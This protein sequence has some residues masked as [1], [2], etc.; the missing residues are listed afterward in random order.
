MRILSVAHNHPS[1]HPGGTEIIADQLTLEYASRRDTSAMLLVGLD[2]YYRMPHSGTFLQAIPGRSDV[3]LF[4]SRGFDA[5]QQIQTRFDS[6]LF[7]LAWFLEEFRPEVVHIHHLNHFGIEFLALVRRIV[8]DAVVVY[9]LH[10]YYLICPNDGQMV[11]TKSDRLCRR[12]SPDACRACFPERPGVVFQV[13][14]LHIQRHLD[15]VDAFCA[16]SEF[17][18]ERFVDWGIPDD[19]IRVVRNGRNWGDQAQFAEPAKGRRR[20]RFGIFGNLRRT[21]G[22]LVAAEAAARLVEAGFTDFSLELFGEDL[23]QK[24]DFSRELDAKIDRAGGRVWRHGRFDLGELPALMDRVDWVLVP[25][26]WW[27]NAPLAIDDAFFF[28]RPVLCSDIGGMAEAVRDGI[29]GVHVRAGDPDAWAAAV[30]RAATDPGLWE[31]L[32]S[33]VD[34]P[35]TIAETADH[36]FALFRELIGARRNSLPVATG[37]TSQTP[38]RKRKKRTATPVR[39]KAGSVRRTGG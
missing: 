5:F 36:Y 29:D 37:A 9:T 24:E 26:T 3:L 25:S 4:R 1:F 2:S 19:R 20:S 23:F 21:K 30:H 39:V 11:T 6:L 15:C 17:I 34:R 8:P 28:G 10:D 22:T 13:R 14:K 33:G 7:D 18:R 12:A 35:R 38:N 32:A 27:E 31:K 16:P